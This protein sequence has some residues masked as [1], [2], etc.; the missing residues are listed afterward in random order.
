[1]KDNMRGAAAIV[2][3]GELKPERTRPGRD[4]M[5]LL[6]EAAYLAIQDAGLTKADIDGMILEEG[7]TP[8]GSGY[9]TKMAEYMGIFPTFATGCDAQGAAG[10]TMALQA[11][12]YINAGLCNYVLCGMSAAIDGSRPRRPAGSGQTETATSEFAAPF[13][14]T[15]GANGWYAMIAKRYEKLYGATVEKRAKISV[16]LRYNANHNP[17][18]IWHDVPITVDDVVNSRIVADPL[19]LLECVM[20]CA[21]AC[22]FIVARADIARGMRHK[23]A[24]VLGGANGVSRGNLTHVGEI[25]ISPVGRAARK[26][27]AMAGYG[28]S[29]VQVMEIYDS[30]TITVMCE[31]EESGFCPKGTAG[32]WVQDHDLTFKGDKPLNTHGGQ[33]SYGQASTAGGCAQVT[34]A[35]RQIR[36]DAG[37]H[38]VPGPTDLIYVTGSGGT[39]SQQSALL[40][41]SDAAL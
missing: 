23:P 21:G 29:D 5:S 9:N 25:T 34:E 19:H 2:G 10:V 35:V 39:F 20:P 18:A 31:L 6:A 7:M 3:I 11:A 27:F 41:A 28:P 36:R 14:P 26:A 12:A 8:T 24:Y 38:Q 1:M 22:A 4:A 15:V 37:E 17:M 13:G 30:F 16:D 33:L 40:L 32:D